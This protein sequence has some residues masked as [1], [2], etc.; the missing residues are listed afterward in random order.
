MLRIFDTDPDAVARQS[1]RFENDFV[2]RFRSGRMVDNRPESLSEWRITT[3]D[4]AVAEA[5]AGMFG[6]HPEE[7]ETTKED[8]LEVMT[9]ASSVPIVIDGPDALKARMVLWGNN[10]AIIHECDGMEFLDEDRK[11]TPCGCPQ[12][13]ADR[14][15]LAKKGIGP[16]PETSL[17]FRL[18]DDP[19]IGKFRFQSASWDLVRD[20]PNLVSALEN[21]GGPANATLAL[22]EVSFTIKNGPRKGMDVTYNRPVITVKGAA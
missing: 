12:L 6:G 11:G 21:I 5:V 17:V 4:P 18:Q 20:F 13:F 10:G 15:A 16:K 2:G 9:N 8:A 19:E 14:K 22:T 1:Q 3:G 7:W